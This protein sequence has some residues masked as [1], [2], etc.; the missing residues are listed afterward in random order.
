MDVEIVARAYRYYR[1]DTQRNRFVGY[2]GQD[3]GVSN[4]PR[5]FFSILVLTVCQT[6]IVCNGQRKDDTTPRLVTTPLQRDGR[7]VY[8]RQGQGDIETTVAA[9]TTTDN[10]DFAEDLIR[11]IQ[12]NTRP[13]LIDDRKPQ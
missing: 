12:Q 13:G 1:Y 10:C 8:I 7:G 5:D 2:R 3:I 11:Y 6:N 4:D 9:F